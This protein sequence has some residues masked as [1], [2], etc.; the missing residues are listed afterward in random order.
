M[1]TEFTY[2]EVN[3]YIEK[4]TPAE[5]SCMDMEVVMSIDFVLEMHFEEYDSISLAEL[6]NLVATEYKDM[7]RD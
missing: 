7:P 5:K 2:E 3:N 4:L 6:I 1:Q